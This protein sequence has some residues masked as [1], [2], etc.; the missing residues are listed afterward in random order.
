MKI[1]FVE[2]SFKF[3]LMSCH[4]NSESWTQA[5]ILHIWHLYSMSE[6]LGYS[7]YM[8]SMCWGF[9]LKLFAVNTYVSFCFF[10][11][12]V[13]LFFICLLGGWLG[14]CRYQNN[15][16]WNPSGEHQWSY[17]ATPCNST[18]PS[19][20]SQM[21]ICL[22]KEKAPRLYHLP[23]WNTVYIVPMDIPDCHLIIIGKLCSQWQNFWL[24]SL[25]PDW[26]CFGDVL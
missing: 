22:Y 9:I 6:R 13:F 10:L 25:R 7:D 8:C 3:F 14:T 1:T 21:C 17:R 11:S 24:I 20:I 23:F 12:L 4:Y 16:S 18:T 19:M 26:L 15:C 2:K 5:V